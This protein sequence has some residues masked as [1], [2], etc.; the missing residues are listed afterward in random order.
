MPIIT[1]A[2]I[3]TAWLMTIVIF[4]AIA[5][6]NATV[7]ANDPLYSNRVVNAKLI[8]IDVGN[9]S[10]VQRSGIKAGYELIEVK[11]N[12]EI[13]DLK[14]ADALKEFFTKHIDQDI[15]IKWKNKS[16]RGESVVTGVYGIIEKKK[17]IGISDGRTRNRLSCSG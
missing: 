13:A 16:D 14:S 3:S 10:P 12:N 15:H 8:V 6:S 11:A 17:A 9:K 7:A 4:F 5:K 1:A 2:S